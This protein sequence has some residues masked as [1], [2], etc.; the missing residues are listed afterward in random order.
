[1]V[2]RRAG[3]TADRMLNVVRWIARISGSLLALS[4]LPAFLMN[5]ATGHTNFAG[6]NTFEVIKAWVLVG[7]VVAQI[8]GIALAWAWEGFGGAVV[9]GGALV[10]MIV[11]AVNGSFPAYE[12][13]FVL[14]SAMFLYLWWRTVGQNQ[15]RELWRVP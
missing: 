12:A 4:M 5:C 1:M 11:G 9:L 14:T 8:V 10:A 2:T 6:L 7:L 3:A 13:L 15:R